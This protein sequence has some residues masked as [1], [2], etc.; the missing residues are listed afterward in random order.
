MLE[1]F[2]ECDRIVRS[3][4]PDRAVAIAFAPLD[5]RRYLGALYAFDAETARIR[6]VV[7]Q[8]LPGEIRLQWWRDRIDAHAADPLEAGGQGS[9]V[10]QALLET[11]TRFDL[12]ADAVR[13]LLDA[14]I[15]DLYDDP[16]PRRAEFEAYA[17]E[18]A[19][20]I[21]I[22]ASMILD[23]EAA[24]RA[25]DAAGH[26][27]VA[28]T[29]VDAI[30][31][32]PRRPQQTQI[33]FPSDILD[34]VGCSREALRTGEAAAAKRSIAAMSAYARE[35]MTAARLAVARLPR[36]LLPAFLPLEATE[37]TL[38]RIERGAVAETAATDAVARLFLY[39]RAMRR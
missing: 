37:R 22:L 29:A 26:A 8:P 2:A 20:A 4:D 12:P 36:T 16:M 31:A 32:L 14:R 28:K 25:A 6:Q 5:R 30:L 13:T 24:S 9:P 11:I 15:F 38:R 3:H 27:G 19:S 18:T 23:R 39:W 1:S 7:S 21:F 17:G 35:H 10:A 34:A 33:F